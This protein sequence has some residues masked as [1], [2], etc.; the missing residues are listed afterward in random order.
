MQARLQYTDFAAALLQLG[1]RGDPSAFHGTLCGALC[2]LPPEELSPDLL[3]DEDDPE[4]DAEGRAVLFELRDLVTEALADIELSF[5]PLLPD[6]EVGLMDRAQALAAWCEGFLYG[7]GASQQFD[8]DACSEEV[9]EVVR[10]FSQF[11]RAGFSS[12]DDVEHEETAYAELVEY[13]R[14][15]AQLVYM[16]L[17]AHARDDDERPTLH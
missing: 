14:V 10:D 2:R 7:L 6:D 8:L 15:G 4:P 9:R 5:T 17:H 16:E 11:T 3:L 12:G 13:V 1:H